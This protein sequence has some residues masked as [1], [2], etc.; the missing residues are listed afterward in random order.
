MPIQASCLLPG[1]VCILG[2]NDS[3]GEKALRR[4]VANYSRETSG[5]EPDV[6]VGSSMGAAAFG[7]LRIRI[8][9]AGLEPTFSAVDV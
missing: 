1:T 8:R 9:S 7:C 4:V 2:S 5:F 3:E 6:L